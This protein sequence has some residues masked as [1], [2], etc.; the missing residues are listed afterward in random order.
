MLSFDILNL[1]LF[2]PFIMLSNVHF[3]TCFFPSKK[4]NKK[5]KRNFYR[6]LGWE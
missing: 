5:R 6:G 3:F 1:I 2:Y 4:K